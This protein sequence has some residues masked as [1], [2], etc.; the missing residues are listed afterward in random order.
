MKKSAALL[1]LPF[2][3]AGCASSDEGPKIP[4]SCPQVAIVRDLERVLDHGQDKP[5]PETFVAGALMRG[6][7][8]SCSYKK[9]GVDISFDLD[10]A[11]EKGPRLGGSQIGFPYFV[12]LVDPDDKIVSKEIMTANFEFPKG[13]SF[14]KK[15]EPIHVFVPLAKDENAAGYRVLIGFQ[16][17]E[18]QFDAV[19]AQRKD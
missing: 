13:G 1:F 18:S 5:V 19:R 16:L 8:G 14:V 2:L 11:A 3:L 15:A 9:D 12:S 7:D 4:R 6:L 10:L 17:T